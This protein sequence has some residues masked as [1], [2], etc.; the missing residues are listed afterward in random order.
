MKVA[1][2]VI[3]KFHTFDL[4]RELHQRDLL[5]GVYSGYPMFKLGNEKI[6]AQLI[7]TFPWLQTPYMAF[8]GRDKLGQRLLRLYEHWN[9]ISFDRYTARN[10]PPCDVF[11]GLSGSALITG[12]QARQRGTRYVCDRGS[13]HIRAQ[14][15]LL[16]QEHALWQE[17]FTGIDPRVIDREE[18][19]YAEADGITVPSGFSART[20]IEQGVPAHKVHRLPYGVNLGSFHATAQPSHQSFDILFAGGASL[21]KGI[22][23]LLQAFQ[24][25]KHPRKRLFFAGAFSAE[26]AQ[27]LQQLG[28]WS[29]QIQLLGHLQQTELRD[30]MSRSSVL[31]LPSIEDGFGLVMAQAMACGCPVVASEN[32]GASDLFTDGDAGYIVPI[33]RA[34]LLAD[35]LQQLADDPALRNAMGQRALKVVQSVGGWQRY[36]D[37]AVSIYASL[38]QQGAPA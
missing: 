30:R 20:F 3:G 7:H 22:P 13:S 18:A 9:R 5:Q 34:D 21:R 31:V 4:A 6:P 1:L 32:T 19:E 23:Y 14:D 17:P 36:G 2:S 11:V 26:F 15:E 10:L 16:A 33:R 27:K 37:E 8:T 24:R 35:R 12:R 25:L 38:L 28:L 29:D